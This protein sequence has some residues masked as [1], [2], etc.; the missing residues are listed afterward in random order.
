MQ[1]VK[2][3]KAMFDAIFEEEHVYNIQKHFRI[4]RILKER[5][6]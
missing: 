3:P 2:D 1:E 5:I 4:S 6:N